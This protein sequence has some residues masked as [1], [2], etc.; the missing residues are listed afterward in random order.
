MT[1]NQQRG[2]LTWVCST[3]DC[4]TP[5]EKG[6]IE[7]LLVDAV[8][9]K[10]VGYILQ[11]LVCQKCRSVKADNLAKRCSCAGS[12][13]TVVSAKATRDLMLTFVKVAQR[14][15]F[16]LLAEVVGRMLSLD[17]Q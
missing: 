2:G 17:K 11:D 16:P 9:R 8:R 3:S 14:F 5:Y 15:E 7:H 13:S 4:R 6:E 12:F 10:T 1:S